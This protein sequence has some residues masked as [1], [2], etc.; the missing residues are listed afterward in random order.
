[1]KIYGKLKLDA[2]SG[3]GRKRATWHHPH[4]YTAKEAK[5]LRSP[6]KL[7]GTGMQNIAQKDGTFA[8]MD[9]AFDLP[10]FS[11]IGMAR[12]S[13]Q[14]RSIHHIWKIWFAAQ[15]AQGSCD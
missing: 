13:S 8:L 9:V 1:M 3:Y 7:I 6:H 12:T 11:N 15:Q 4:V 2:L 5:Q 14:Q 10:D